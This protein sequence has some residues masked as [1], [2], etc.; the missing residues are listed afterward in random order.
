[1]RTGFDVSCRDFFCLGR[2]PAIC[3][4]QGTSGVHARVS[5]VDV[6]VAGKLGSTL[7]LA[8]S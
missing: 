5:Y 1:M 8:S 7:R 6:D 2:L 4:R 3:G